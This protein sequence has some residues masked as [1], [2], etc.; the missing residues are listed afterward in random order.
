M[1][2]AALALAVAGLLA[3]QLRE[4]QVRRRSFRQAVSVAAVGAGDVIVRPQRLADAHRD[5]LLTYIQVGQSGH[6]SSGVEIVHSLLEETNGDHLTVH[7]DKF[8]DI[9][10]CRRLAC[11]NSHGALVSLP[12]ATI[13]TLGG[14]LLVRGNGINS[15]LFCAAAGIGATIRVVRNLD[16]ESREV[17]LQPRTATVQTALMKVEPLDGGRLRFSYDFVYPRGGVQH[18]EWDGRFDGHDY[19]VQR[20]DE[21]ATYAYRQTGERTYEITAKLDSRVTAVAAVTMSQDG[22]SRRRL[23]AAA[24]EVSSR[25]RPCMKRRMGLVSRLCRV[26]DSTWNRPAPS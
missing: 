14:P 10:T 5:R 25:T 8:L 22:R 16:A 15:L 20:A 26:Q 13:A 11:R 21:Y 24:P 23:E 18:V 3:E 17:R 4:H 2:R 6:Q 7:M 19:I 12:D 9:E 1:H